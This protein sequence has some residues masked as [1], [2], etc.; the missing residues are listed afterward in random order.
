VL[1]GA[2][3]YTYLLE[4][5]RCTHQSA[6]ERNY[7][8]FHMLLAQPADTLREQFNLLPPSA[9]DNNTPGEAAGDAAG[10][11]ATTCAY[12]YVRAAPAD[13]EGSGVIE[14]VSDAARLARTEAALRLVGVG[15]ELVKQLLEVVAAVV[16]LG[17][18]RDPCPS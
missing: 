7:H 3:C 9:P 10:D 16:H 11:A 1:V 2:R 13:E 5:S 17:Q 8:A 4:K 18:V 14:G 12:S 6:G 15:G